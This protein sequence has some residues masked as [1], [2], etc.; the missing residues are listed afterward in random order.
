MNILRNKFGFSLIE[1]LVA[2]AV[3]SILILPVTML[4]TT[5]KRGLAQE[6]D[7]IR[8]LFL[9]QKVMEEAREK[10]HRNPK[11]RIEPENFSAPFDGFTCQVKRIRVPEESE[12]ID[13]VVTVSWKDQKQKKHSVSISSYQSRRYEL[14][15]HIQRQSIWD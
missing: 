2:L 11:C 8:A 10:H 9:A 4:F 14:V 5:G 15:T 3:L 7:Y 1:I 13:L 12:L 6:E